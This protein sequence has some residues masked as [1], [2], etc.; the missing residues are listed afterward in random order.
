MDTREPQT[1]FHA[2]LAAQHRYGCRKPC[3]EDIA[4]KEDSYQTLIRNRWA[5]SHS[6]ALYR[7]RG[8]RRGCCLPERHHHRGGDLRASLRNRI[9]AM[10]NYTAGANGLN[11]AMLAAGIQDHRHLAPVFWRRASWT[12]LPEHAG[13]AGQLVYLEI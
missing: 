3:I 6:A 9:P 5:S 10:L 2:L 12:H 4:F 7:R 1:L 13:D 8:T 11:S